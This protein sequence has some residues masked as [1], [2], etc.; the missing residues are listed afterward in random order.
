MA[1]CRS[2][3]AACRNHK[4]DCKYVLEY[5]TG[6]CGGTNAGDGGGGWNY[7]FSF[8][9]ADVMP[10]LHTRF[11]VGSSWGYCPESVE[12]RPA[13]YVRQIIGER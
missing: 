10:R 5:N 1:S 8:R 7:G 11:S 12:L 4:S 6:D 9:G 13:L 3:E 2:R